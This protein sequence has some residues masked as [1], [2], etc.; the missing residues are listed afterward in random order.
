MSRRVLFTLTAATMAG[1]LIGTVWL[2]KDAHRL[3]VPYDDGYNERCDGHARDN[4]TE[5]QIPEATAFLSRRDPQRDAFFFV[6]TS[7]LGNVNARQACAV[8]S[9]ARLHPEADVYLLLLSPAAALNLSAN[10]SVQVLLEHYI[11]VHV[12]YVHLEDYFRD[13]LLEKWYQIGTLRASQYQQSHTSDA[14]RFFTLWKYG[15]TYL[16]LDIVLIKSLKGLRNFAGAESNLD[17]AAGV[18]NFEPAQNNL[19]LECVLEIRDN[20]R[21]DDW[22]SNGPGVITR[23]L[24]RRCATRRVNLM[25][26]ERCDGF[27]VMPPYAFYPVTWKKWKL[28]FD[29]AHSDLTMRSLNQSYGIHVWNKF[30]ITKQVRVGSKQPYGLVAQQFCPR[31]YDSSGK[32]F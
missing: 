2:G 27:L 5:R 26:R 14:F 6:E 11:N 21:G 30:S 15:G 17:I 29:E 3:L 20:F 9:A 25:N 28:Y 12:L 24:Q 1:L 7:C 16:D 18:L 19:A 4:S 13:S 31:V 32:I 10:P 22:G 23:V 8:E